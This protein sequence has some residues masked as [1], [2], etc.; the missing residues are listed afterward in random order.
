MRQRFFAPIKEFTH[1]FIARLTQIDYA[2]S[3]VLVALDP[4][5]GEMLGAVR[6]HADPD[7]ENAE[8]AIFVRSD[9]QGRGLG[10]SLMKLIID[11]GRRQGTKRIYGQV[12]VENVRMLALARD[13]GFE[14]ARRGFR[15]LL[16]DT[17]PQANL[18]SWL[19]VRE[20]A[21]EET[22][23]HLVDTGQLPTPRRLSEWGLDLIP[24]SLDL[25][26]V[27]V[28]LMQRPLSTLLL[29][30]ALR[31]TEGYDFVLIDSLPSLGHLAALGA[32]AG[33]GLLVP[34]ETSVKGVEA[35]VGVMEAAQEYREALEQV[36]P[37]VP[38]SFVRLFIP[39][40][41]DARTLGDNRVLEKIAG[42]ED[43]APVASPIA[44]RPGPHRR[45]TERAVPLQLVG[46]R[47]AREEVERLAEEFLQRV[48]AQDAV[49]E[50]VLEEVAE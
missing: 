14:L 46:D 24:A 23:L 32:L 21:P 6:L 31:K 8:Y 33:D 25:A 19:G 11:Y 40:K 17:D 15:V 49:R 37:R 10:L 3:M 20:V 45:A 48:V 35:L 18:T 2:R 42:L 38:R 36:D 34:V 47:Q 9:Q 50:G 44:Y 1:A 7:N 16:V 41:F 28:R 22:L 13:L 12:L 30:T 39:T 27:E 4:D 29:R 43:L 5:S 26:R